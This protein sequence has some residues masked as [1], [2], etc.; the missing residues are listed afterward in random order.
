MESGLGTF[1]PQTV[2]VEVTEDEVTISM[3][4]WATGGWCSFG[5]GSPMMDGTYAIVAS[6]SPNEVREYVLNKPSNSQKDDFDMSPYEVETGLTILENSA[7]IMTRYATVTRP[8]VSSEGYSFPFDAS[9]NTPEFQIDMISAK[10]DYYEPYLKYHGSQC[11]AYEKLT[12]TV[13]G[14]SDS[15]SS[16]GGGGSGGGSN[17]GGNGGGGSNG[18]GNGGNGGGS[19]G[20]GGNNHNNNNNNRG[21]NQ[22]EHERRKAELFVAPMEGDAEAG[23]ST[24]EMVWGAALLV[25]A[26]FVI[27]QLWRWSTSDGHKLEL[28]TA[29]EEDAPLLMHDR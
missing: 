26:A 15:G 9:G 12:L 5:F 13:S 10:A 8:R 2:S 14:G 22:H 7:D 28:S 19:G 24:T 11:R 6:N 17:G 3:E 18:G 16:S 27:D 4:C 1:P 25:V 20:H 21:N 23:L 29:E